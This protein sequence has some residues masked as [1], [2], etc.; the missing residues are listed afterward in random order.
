[1]Q[2]VPTMLPQCGWAKGLCSWAEGPGDLCCKS[3]CPTASRQGWPG[4][5]SRRRP[6]QGAT[7]LQNPSQA[8][9]QRYLFCPPDLV[10][11]D[12]ALA[13]GPLALGRVLPVRWRG[14]GF[15]HEVR[16]QVRIQARESLQV[17][18]LKRTAQD[19]S[20]KPKHTDTAPKYPAYHC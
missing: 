3:P 10:I 1:M 13:G 4:Q 5:P 8:S 20:N 19:V 7:D 15:L 2:D 9:L 17:S 6:P 12:D 11:V 16:L 14:P 18:L